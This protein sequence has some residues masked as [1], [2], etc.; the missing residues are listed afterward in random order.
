[1][2]N[3]EIVTYLKE[4]KKRGFSEDVL[5]KKLLDGGFNAKE[6]DEATKLMGAAPDAAAKPAKPVAAV[7]PAAGAAMPGK[8]GEMPKKKSKI[9]IWVLVLI[10][11]V[12]LIL[13][14]LFVF[15]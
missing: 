15:F 2:V 4:G 8:P 1:M 14:G 5:K 10:L 11:I 9:W 3:Q 6:I 12:I 7:K 13:I